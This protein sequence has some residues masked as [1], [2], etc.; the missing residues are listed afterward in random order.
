MRYAIMVAAFGMVLGAPVLAPTMVMST[1]VAQ[2]A[3][4]DAL[5]AEIIAAGDDLDALAAIISREMSS[6]N[7]DGLASALASAATTVASTD[8]ALAA[9]LINQAIVIGDNASDDTQQAVGEAASVVSTT[10]TNAGDDNS[11]SAVED[12]VA[13]ALDSDMQSAYNNSGGT[14]NP[15]VPVGGGDTGGG[16]DFGGDDQGGD[17]QG[18]DDQGGGD[19]ADDTTPV[20]AITPPAPGGGPPPQPP[21]TIVVVPIVLEPNPSQSGSPT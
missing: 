11:A 10:A 21:I 18:G 7:F 6:G 3:V 5:A 1:A 2:D 16:D 9:T 19:P 14:S 15:T 13:G 20:G 12:A 17:D 8:V 4:A